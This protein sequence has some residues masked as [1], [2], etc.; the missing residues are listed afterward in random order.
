[1]NVTFQVKLIK[2][3][4]SRSE[5]EDS[6]RSSLICLILTGRKPARHLQVL[7]RY[8]VPFVSAEAGTY[9]N[10]FFNAWQTYREEKEPLLSIWASTFTLLVVLKNKKRMQDEA[11]VR[12]PRLGCS[13]CIFYQASKRHC[14]LCLLSLFDFVEDVLGR[15]KPMISGQIF[16]VKKHLDLPR[17]FLNVLFA[18]IYSPVPSFFTQRLPRLR[19]ENTRSAGNIASRILELTLSTK[20]TILFSTQHCLKTEAAEIIKKGSIL[21]RRVFV[22]CLV[23]GYHRPAGSWRHSKA[24]FYSPS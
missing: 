5:R 16:W 7:M 9:K 14:F 3:R 20:K 19:L 18:L 11:A 4:E 15:V 2:K 22:C 24:G 12:P 8:V 10:S 13:T 23:A 6:L 21:L 17:P 1:M